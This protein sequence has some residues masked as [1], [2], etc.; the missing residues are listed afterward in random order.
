MGVLPH[1]S[2]LLW[3]LETARPLGVPHDEHPMPLLGHTKVRGSKRL[4]FSLI[5]RQGQLPNDPIKDAVA[6]ALDLKH[7]RKGRKRMGNVVGMT[8]GADPQ[9]GADS[10]TSFPDAA[11]CYVNP[12]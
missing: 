6:I 1:I 5:P 9:C 3:P 2:T 12:F 11:L 8:G 10:D 4:G 7:A